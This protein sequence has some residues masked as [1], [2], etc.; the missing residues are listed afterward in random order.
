MD[1]SRRHL[2]SKY[3]IYPDHFICFFFCGGEKWL[4]GVKVKALILH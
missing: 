3:N 4:G 1:L 2:C